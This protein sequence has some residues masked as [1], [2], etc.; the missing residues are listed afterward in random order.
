MKTSILELPEKVLVVVEGDLDTPSCEQFKAGLAPLMEK[1]GLH[2]EMDMSQVPYISS[3]GLRVL[4]A[5]V[6]AQSAT[7]GSVK[8][9]SVTPTVKEVFELTGFDKILLYQ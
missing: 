1:A 9:L 2:V 4:L 8:V 3:R 7:G 5:L 6:Q